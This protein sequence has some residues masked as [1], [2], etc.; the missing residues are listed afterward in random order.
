[1]QILLIHGLARTS[2]SLLTLEWRLRDAGYTTHSFSYFAFAESFDQIVERLRTKIRSLV[3]R[4]PYGIAAHS[5]GGVLTRA[6]LGPG[7]LAHPFHT[8][9]LGTPN[10]SPRLASLAWQVPPFRWFTGQC[11][12]NLS[13]HEFYQDLPLL[14]SPYTII[15]G[16]GGPTGALS[17]FGEEVNDG[18]VA[19]SETCLTPADTILE[20]PVWHTFMMN[21]PQ[22]QELALAALGQNGES[23]PGRR[24]EGISLTS[25]Q[26]AGQSA[27]SWSE[28]PSTTAAHRASQRL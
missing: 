15:A 5:L 3:S 24:E 17:P 9:M 25:I 13:R 11:G 12:F 1:M 8:V 26:S 2:F 28:S 10:Q 19:L 18:I 21:H 20:V 7:D 23:V 4:G 6:A 14:R 27:G 22:V 16:T